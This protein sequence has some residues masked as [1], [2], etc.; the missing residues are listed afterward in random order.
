MHAFDYNLQLES[1]GQV[2]SASR[3]YSAQTPPV[4]LGLQK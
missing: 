4:D 1:L 2:S 3:I